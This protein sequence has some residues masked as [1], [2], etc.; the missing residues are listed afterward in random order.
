MKGQP[1][2]SSP[3]AFMERFEIP[4]FDQPDV[5]YLVRWRLV[6]T[7]WGSL[8][9]HRMNT[10]D[11]RPTFHDHPWAFCS[12]VLRG[13]Y[14]E[15]R[16]LGDKTVRRRCVRRVNVMRRDDAHYVESLLRVPTW[17]FLFVGARRRTWGYWRPVSNIECLNDLSRWTWTPFDRDEHQDEFDAIK[18]ARR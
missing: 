16:L 7:P 15:Q 5:D 9:L 11:S 1:G 8:Y 4:N 18:A 10:P 12:I 13:G 2:K 14:W 6:Q 3:W 17:T